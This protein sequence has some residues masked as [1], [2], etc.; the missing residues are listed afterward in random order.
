[1]FCFLS[2]LFGCSMFV[3]CCSVRVVRCALVVAGCLL[4]VV[5]CLLFGVKVFCLLFVF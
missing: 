4:R 1:M 3:D 5:C 2:L